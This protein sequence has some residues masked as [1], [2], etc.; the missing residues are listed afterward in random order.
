MSKEYHGPI[1]DG[2]LYYGPAL[3][4]EVTNTI[5]KLDIIWSLLEGNGYYYEEDFK[6]NKKI[7]NSPIEDYYI[8]LSIKKFDN[9]LQVICNYLQDKKTVYVHCYAGHGRTGIALACLF[10]KYLGYS[11]EEALKNTEKLCNGPEREV[12]KEFVRDYEKHL[13][14]NSLK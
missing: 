8:P 5:P 6:T 11:A 12:Q 9:D 13:N 10:I 3:S 2:L 7:L 1:L 4:H 14:N